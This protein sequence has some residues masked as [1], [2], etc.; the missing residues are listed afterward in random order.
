LPA[1]LKI[2]SKLGWTKR[3]R[4]AMV[5]YP[6]GAISRYSSFTTTINSSRKEYSMMNVLERCITEEFLPASPL[7]KVA[8]V[9]PGS[10]CVFVLSDPKPHTMEGLWVSLVLSLTEKGLVR[11]IL[12]VPM[13]HHGEGGV[14]WVKDFQV[15]CV[16]GATPNHTP[17]LGENRH[18][19]PKPYPPLVL[20]NNWLF[21]G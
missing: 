17:W 10:A 7:G 20:A 11:G 19:C 16:S 18:T 6:W 5:L 2:G 14:I 3:S 8:Q 21:G 12:D 13:T 4:N 15:L 1:S 9:I